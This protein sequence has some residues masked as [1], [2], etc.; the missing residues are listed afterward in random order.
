MPECFQDWPFEIK[1]YAM[2]MFIR[3]QFWYE[4]AR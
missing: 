2:G 1:K 3:I 4:K